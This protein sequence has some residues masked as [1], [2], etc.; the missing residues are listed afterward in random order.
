MWNFICG[1][2]CWVGLLVGTV[3][4][5]FAITVTV[6]LAP[7]WLTIILLLLALFIFGGIARS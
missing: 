6:T 5:G 3:I 2:L 4:L 7:F 1:G